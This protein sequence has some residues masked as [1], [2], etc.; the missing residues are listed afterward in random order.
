MEKKNGLLTIEIDSSLYPD[1]LITKGSDGPQSVD[2][3]ASS[4]QN[5][6]IY[7]L[8]SV[9]YSRPYLVGKYS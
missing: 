8:S 4:F 9:D 2:L 1:F 6:N 5:G 7:D 3:L